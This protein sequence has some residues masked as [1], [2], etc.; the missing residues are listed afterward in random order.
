MAGVLGL[1]AL[2]GFAGIL[3]LPLY[4]LLTSWLFKYGYVLLEAAAD[5][6]AEPPVLSLEMVNPVEQRP[7]VQLFICAC[8]YFLVRWIGGAPGLIVAAVLLAFLPASV[9]ILGASARSLDVVNPVAIWRT[10]RGLG[11]DYAVILG[12]IA[13][14]GFLAASLD[15]LALPAIVAIAVLLFGTLSI[16][17]L[18]GG[19]LFE[20]REELGL[21]PRTS[22]ER[23][24]ERAIEERLRQRERMLDATY[25]PVR[26]REYTRALVPLQRWLEAASAADL[27][28]D[29][30][31]IIHRAAAWNDERALADVAGATLARLINAR[32]HGVA[33][34]LSDVVLQ[35]LP[36][37]HLPTAA[38]TLVLARYAQSVGRRKSALHLLQEFDQRFPAHPLHAEAASLRSELER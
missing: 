11:A 34:S 26:V 14:Y 24:Q 6:A 33:L 9:A 3:G 36:A 10:V 37:F 17:C 25:E 12:V 2:A 27:A 28:T 8:A 21:E 15:R 23:L 4:L 5:G 29:A 16:F 30:P 38:D 1:F 35:K 32:Q 13:L 7:L 20:H 18:I 19:A 31:A 22:P